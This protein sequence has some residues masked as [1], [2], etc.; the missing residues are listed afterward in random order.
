MMGDNVGLSEGVLEGANDVVGL[1]D[2]ID[3]T[4]G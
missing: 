4:V 2:G 3:D 1:T